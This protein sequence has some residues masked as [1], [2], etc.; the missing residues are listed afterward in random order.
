[1]KSKS[2]AVFV[3]VFAVAASSRAQTKI[4]GTSTC[5]K[6]EVQHSL[7]VG[8]LPEHTYNMSQTK[9]KWTKGW[10]V[11]GVAAGQEVATGFSEA[12]ANG[13]RDHGRV[14]ENM[15]NGDKIF[16]SYRGTTTIKAGAPVRAQ[17]TWSYT[18]GTGKFKG[19]KGKGTFLST[20]N[21]DESWTVEV[22]G[23]YSLPK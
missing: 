22:E 8:D 10:E 21:A 17:G 15:S 18:G 5:A 14:V 16:V 7:E 9:C 2:L 20:P 11:A 1:M 12:R 4:S 23:E 19:I 6:P 13:S 3:L